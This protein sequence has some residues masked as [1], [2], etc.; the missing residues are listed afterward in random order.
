M[1]L[2]YFARLQRIAELK[3][4]G[5]ASGGA[6]KRQRELE[7][8]EED[9]PA[10]LQVTAD[11]EP[12][13]LV[14]K[15]LHGIPDAD[16]CS[17]RRTDEVAKEAEELCVSGQYAAAVVPLQR[18]VYLGHMPSLALKSWLLIVSREGAGKDEMRGF[19]LAEEGARLGCH[20]CQGAVAWCY[21]GGF[22][23]VRDAARSDFNGMVRFR[24]GLVPL[25]LFCPLH[26]C[27]CVNGPPCAI[28]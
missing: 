9:A 12:L 26:P 17:A 16:G 11:A 28:S 4:S 8:K 25:F 18:A 5:R 2:Q 3:M 22:G 6:V 24:V 14:L 7:V 20:H 19:E 23:C 13:T 15:L 10:S 27:A 21:R 1:K